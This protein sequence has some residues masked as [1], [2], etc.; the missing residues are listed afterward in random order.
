MAP[1]GAARNHLISCGSFMTYPRSM[2]LHLWEGQ[3]PEIAWGARVWKLHPRDLP[4]S[5]WLW[6]DAQAV[7]FLF[8][9][10]PARFRGELFQVRS[11][12][13]SH[14]YVRVTPRFR[15]NIE[16]RAVPLPTPPPSF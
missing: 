13:Q 15:G 2:P 12:P 16:K 8:Q 10:T 3:N 11:A 14:T 5:L 9:R 4:S 7:L 1:A 6:L